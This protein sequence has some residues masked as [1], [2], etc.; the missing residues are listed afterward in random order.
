MIR[1]R[2]KDQSARTRSLDLKCQHFC[3]FDCRHLQQPDLFIPLSADFD[4]VVAAAVDPITPF[5]S[6]PIFPSSL[7]F[8]F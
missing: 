3:S 4:P 5:V 6:V 7:H 1:I 8:S 2:T